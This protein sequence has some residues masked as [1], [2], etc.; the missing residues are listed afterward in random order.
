MQSSYQLDTGKK[1]IKDIFSS[2]S[3]Y[4]IP[5]YQRPYVW[6]KDQ[7]SALLDDIRQAIDNDPK[8]E[9]FVGCMVWNTKVISDNENS[10]YI[11]QDI[12]DGQQR[13]I[14][15]YLLHAVIRDLTESQTMRQK[16]QERMKQEEHDEYDGIP[17][18]N[19]IEFSIRHDRD[20]LESYVLKTN[21]TRNLDALKNIARSKDYELSVRNMATAILEMQDWFKTLQSEENDFD[22]YLSK[23]FG[24][25][26]KNILII[27][28]STPNNLDD[29]YNLF[30][31]LNSRGLQLQA[32]DIIRAQNLRNIQ[33]ASTRKKYAK[34]WEEYESSIDEPYQ[35]FDEFL[36]AIVSIKM[37]YRSDDNKSISK[38]FEFMY[39]RKIMERGEKTFDMIGQYI[40]HLQALND[41]MFCRNE[42]GNFFANLHRILTATYGN[43]YATPILHYRECFGNYRICDCLIKIDNLCSVYWLTGKRSLQSRIFI[44]LRKIEEIAKKN[45][46]KKKAADLFLKSPVLEY[47]Y[48]DKKASTFLDIEHFFELLEYENFGSY[49]GAKINKSRY[50]LLKLDLLLSNINTPLN[51][52]KSRISIEHLIPKKFDSQTSQLTEDEHSSW[53]YRLGNIVLIDC[54]KSAYISN[55]S[56]GEKKEKYKEMIKNRPNTKYLFTKYTDWGLE[57][58]KE[59][60]RRVVEILQLYYLGNSLE[61]AQEIIK[62]NQIQ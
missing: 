46:D 20:F 18:R 21:G 4:N 12:L 47:D 28:L 32:S 51:L 19:R 26:G 9:Y 54:K 14:T 8:K 52:N 1:Y 7:I 40:N 27:Y 2:D 43:A 33:E 31:V 60:H 13:F 11:C 59:N 30:T 57:Q 25:I 5:E 36:W 15:L 42:S 38:A 6:G 50:L 55:K 53:I 35:S 16:I 41:P 44:I 48:Q 3:F 10:T 34:Y 37:K 39:D 17:A 22:K 61:T 58:V 29:A 56:F 62:S 23:Y 49:A 45:S 24:Y